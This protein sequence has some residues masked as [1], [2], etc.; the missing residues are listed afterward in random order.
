MNIEDMNE[1]Y[2]NLRIKREHICSSCEFNKFNFCSRCGCLIPLK[3]SFP[4]TSCPENKWQSLIQ[5]R[6]S[7]ESNPP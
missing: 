5:E 7:T 2:K 3:I 6:I 1:E 4:F